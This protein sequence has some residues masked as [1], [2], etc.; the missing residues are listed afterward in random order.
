MGEPRV[1]K[2]SLAGRDLIIETGVLAQQAQGSVSVRYGDSV[3][4]VTAW[5]KVSVKV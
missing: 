5:Q 4:L 2:T 1:F 3:V